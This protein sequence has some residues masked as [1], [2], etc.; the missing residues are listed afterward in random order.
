MSSYRKCQTAVS[1]DSEN[2]PDV[3]ASLG[4]AGGLHHMS[5]ERVPAVA[6]SSGWVGDS[7]Q[8]GDPWGRFD[9]EDGGRH[10]LAGPYPESHSVL[11]KH[12]D[13]GQVTGP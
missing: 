5:E 7:P 12:H 6:Q 8:D 9:F 2:V 4:L 13:L 10:G 1:T 11:C 3:V